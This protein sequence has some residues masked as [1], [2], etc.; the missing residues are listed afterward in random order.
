MM[1][2]MVDILV[3]TDSTL[4]LHCAASH[5]E[6]KGGGGGGERER[7]GSD[8]ERVEFG[9]SSKDNSKHVCR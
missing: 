8:T 6:R 1:Q 3:Y 7:G 9:K 5:G 4:I 2:C